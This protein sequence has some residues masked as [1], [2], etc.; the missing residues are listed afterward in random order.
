LIALLNELK[1]GENA[2]DGNKLGDVKNLIIVGHHPLMAL[3]TKIKNG[4]ATDKHL[5][6]HEGGLIEFMGT[7][8]SHMNKVLKDKKYSITYL[9]ADLHM[10]QE[11]ELMV[12]GKKIKQ[13][14]CGTGGTVLD[15]L[16]DSDIKRYHSTFKSKYPEAKFKVTKNY[17]SYGFLTCDINESGK[18]KFKFIK[19]EN[20][21]KSG[22]DK[23]TKKRFAIFNR[24]KTK[25][26][27]KYVKNM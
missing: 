21:N 10:Y 7:I 15:D 23:G 26:N 27:K 1:S 6:H 2:A 25:K 19:V 18:C 9:C 22:K 11:G 3:E 5:P 12:A 14:T 17:L 4:V 8:I 24:K 20:N 16:T 13:Y